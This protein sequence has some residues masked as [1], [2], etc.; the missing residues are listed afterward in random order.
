M[1]SATAVAVIRR[2]KC[3]GAALA[4]PGR[5]K[6][7]VLKTTLSVGTRLPRIPAERVIPDWEGAPLPIGKYICGDLAL[8]DP[9]PGLVPPSSCLAELIADPE[10]QRWAR[11]CAWLPGTGQ[12]RKRPCSTECLFRPLRETEA[13]RLLRLRRQR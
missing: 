7:T 9:E 13:R 11:D 8:S 2:L 1:A 10:A 6:H 3:D 5:G 12:C 4:A